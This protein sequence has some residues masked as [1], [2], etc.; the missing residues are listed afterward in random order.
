MNRSVQTF[1]DVLALLDRLF[2][3]RADRWTTNGGAAWWDK[4]YADRGRD[5]PFFRWAP[6]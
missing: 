1:D 4:F 6:D 3:E 5:V 2:D